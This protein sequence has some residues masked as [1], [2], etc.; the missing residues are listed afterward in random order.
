MKHWTHIFLLDFVNEKEKKHTQHSIKIY[1]KG[2]LN[3]K[4]IGILVR[5]LSLDSLFL[6]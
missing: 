1:K 4:G 2:K 5:R 3:Y 6:F